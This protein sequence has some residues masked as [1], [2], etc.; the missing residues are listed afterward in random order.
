MSIDTCSNMLAFVHLQKGH[1]ENFE[2]TVGKPKWLNSPRSIFMKMITARNP[3][4][5]PLSFNKWYNTVPS[6]SSCPNQSRSKRF[7]NTK[8]LRQAAMNKYIGHSVHQP[9]QPHLQI[10][11]DLMAAI[12]CLLDETKLMPHIPKEVSLLPAR[13]DVNLTPSRY[14][15]SGTGD[16]SLLSRHSRTTLWFS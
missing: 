10:S 2:L 4:S 6:K 9:L 13:G 15:A 16:G 14:K 1:G 11:S 12:R 5:T 7:P 3:K 8:H